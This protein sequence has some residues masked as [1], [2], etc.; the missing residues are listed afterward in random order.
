MLT[1]IP[2]VFFLYHYVHST[3]ISVSLPVLIRVQRQ[4]PLRGPE[5]S[6]NL[7]KFWDGLPHTVSSVHWRQLERDYESTSTHSHTHR[8]TRTLTRM[9]T[10]LS[11]KHRESHDLQN[12]LWNNEVA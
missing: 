3:I 6:C 5:S 2:L 7:R 12:Q 9:M 8:Q 1:F 4:Q 11:H 10:R